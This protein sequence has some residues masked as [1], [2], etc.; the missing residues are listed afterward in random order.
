MLIALAGLPA[1]GKS[2]IAQQLARRMGAV[3]LRIDSM[4]QAIWASG[5]APKDLRDWTYRAAQAVASDNLALGWDIIADCVNDCEDARSG[6]DEIGRRNRAEIIWLEIV[7]SDP[8]EHRRR[9]ETRSS[10]IAGLV[11]PDW[12]AVIQRSYDGWSRSRHVV[13][14]AH[15]SL[16]TCVDE[17]LAIVRR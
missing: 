13:D 9:V 3:W 11:L 6:W 14:T 7:C 15:R 1:A 16:E 8:V 4:D 12:E 10:D 2:S 17:V 5:T